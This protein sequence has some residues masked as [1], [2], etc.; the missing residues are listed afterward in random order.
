MFGL[1]FETADDFRKALRD[2][3]SKAGGTFTPG[4]P[5][6]FGLEVIAQ[7]ALMQIQA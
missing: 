4:R 2:A 6:P 3:L 1:G 7:D 5:A